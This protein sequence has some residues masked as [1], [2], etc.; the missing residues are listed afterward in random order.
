M[1]TQQ[2]NTQAEPLTRM[3]TTWRQKYNKMSSCQRKSC[4]HWGLC[5]Q[6]SGFVSLAFASPGV[7]NLQSVRALRTSEPTGASGRKEVQ[8]QLCSLRTGCLGVLPKWF[9]SSE[10]TGQPQMWM[11]LQLWVSCALFFTRTKMGV[12]AMR[13]LERPSISRVLWG[14]LMGLQGGKG[15]NSFWFE[16]LVKGGPWS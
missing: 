12:I 4:P 2:L 8:G 11:L 1:T 10:S 5:H 6:G 9:S 7:E 15:T 16:L 14:C 3:H 13:P